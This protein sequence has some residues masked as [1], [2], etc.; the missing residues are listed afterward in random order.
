MIRTFILILLF[1]NFWFVEVMA[2]SNNLDFYIQHAIANS[3]LL[4]DYQNQEL[5][6]GVDSLLIKAAYR[7]HVNAM[8][9]NIYYPVING[10]SYDRAITNGGLY[11]AMFGANQTI[12]GRKNISTQL[13]SIELI[14]ES[15]KNNIK[16]SEQDLKKNITDQ[17]ITAYGDLTQFNMNKQLIDLLKKEESILKN[18]TENGVY[19][20][21]DYL[22]FLV[23]VQQQDLLLIQLNIQ[24]K[25]DFATLNYLCG[26]TDTGSVTLPEPVVQ[27]EN[28]PSINNSS[29]FKQF[30]LD[31]L[32]LTNHKML[33]D[34]NY[35]PKLNVFSDAGYNSTFTET[36]YKNFGASLGF[37]VTLPIYDGKQRKMQ[38]SKVDIADKTRIAYKN[39][40]TNQ[41]KQRIS[42]LTQQLNSINQ[43]IDQINI[44][45]K[46]SE[47]L[48]STQRTLL[49][50]G[51]THITDYLMAITNYLNIKNQLT[52]NSVNRLRIIN[53]INYWNR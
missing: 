8:S 45:I 21:T 32:K 7:P 53:Q 44:Q 47:T 4:N 6:N 16:I 17:Y 43:L 3:P 22:T 51:D 12:I 28:L 42:Q 9:T 35:Q 33:V 20:Q 26:I 41:Y 5:S 2:Q 1:I 30:V 37:S 29:F 10:Y 19:R 24:Y 18:L 48:I 46:Y 49:Q 15:L 39:F 23:S 38:Y 40:F 31:S 14:N 13:E 27:I 36:P 11:S 34:L 50:T 52:I 25:N